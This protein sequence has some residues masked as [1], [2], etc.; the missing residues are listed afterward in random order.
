MMQANEK[1]LIALSLFKVHNVSRLKRICRSTLFPR[2]I[3]GCWNS[4][5]SVETWPTRHPFGER[6][7]R[8]LTLELRR[9]GGAID[10]G[11]KKP[12]TD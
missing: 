8:Y 9:N 2:E 11:N 4:Y 6:S 7:G 12:Q 1:S 3:W 10:D 5:D